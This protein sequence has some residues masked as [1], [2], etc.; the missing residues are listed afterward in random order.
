MWSKVCKFM[1]KFARYFALG[2]SK[3]V[4]SDWK[5]LTC[6]RF[7]VFLLQLLKDTCISQQHE[8]TVACSSKLHVAKNNCN[9]LI[10]LLAFAWCFVNK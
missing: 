4:L 7:W 9:F 3:S 5:K 2:L 1:I 10:L 8:I 6:V